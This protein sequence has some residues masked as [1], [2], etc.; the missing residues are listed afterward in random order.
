MELSTLFFLALGLSMDAFA[1]S[2]SNGL[3]YKGIGK[4]QIVQ[5]A[6][7]FGLF[8]AAMPIIGFYAGTLF[9]SAIS[10]YDHWIALILLSLIGGNM[11]ID[12]I[13]ELKNPQECQTKDF[14]L[15]I[16]LMQGVA[17]SIDALAVGV[18]LSVMKTDIFSAASIIGVT[19]FV[20]CLIGA[21][22]GKKFGE[23]LKQEAKIFGGT[24]LIIIGL[25]IFLGHTLG[26]WTN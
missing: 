21:A 19:T 14:T 18:S 12:A 22:F 8:Q 9:S 15:S 23:Y 24:I 13:K 2:I 7:T 5:T 17:T 25:K 26:I 20:C 3:Y 6:L 16:L 4:K 11:I 1:V 10:A